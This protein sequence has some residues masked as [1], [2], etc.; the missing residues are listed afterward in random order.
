MRG[1]L[2]TSGANLPLH[3]LA[4]PEL[5]SRVVTLARPASAE[6]AWSGMQQ[7]LTQQSC[8]AARH[9]TGACGPT[10]SCRLHNS[11][12]GRRGSSQ[13]F[14]FS[15]HPRPLEAMTYNMQGVSSLVCR[16]G[17][18]PCRRSKSRRRGC[19]VRCLLVEPPAQLPANDSD[20]R[21]QLGMRGRHQTHDGGLGVP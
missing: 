8:T 15:S 11:A 19:S 5:Q 14:K 9:R 20:D 6:Q 16:R 21:L 18:I 10:A 12:G 4:P 1:C 3:E 13:L 7:G 17:E 2:L